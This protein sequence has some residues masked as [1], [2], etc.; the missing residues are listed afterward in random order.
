MSYNEWLDIDV[1]EDYLDG[2]LDASTMHKIERISLE[3]P[4]V[5]E[6]LEGLSQSPKRTQTLSLLQKQL[7]ARITQKPIEAKRWRI[8]SQRL[9]IAAA[10]AVLFVTV[11]ILFWMKGSHTQMM[12]KKTKQ[13]GV[14]SNSQIT[15]ASPQFKPNTTAAIAAVK[16]AAIKNKPIAPPTNKIPDIRIP[17]N[18]V[19]PVTQA[20][21]VKPVLAAVLTTTAPQNEEPVAEAPASAKMVK[22]PEAIR[23][24][25][26]AGKAP[27]IYVESNISSM[28]LPYTI[29][30]KVFTKT[31]GSPLPGALVKIAG[32]NKATVTN[33]RGEFTLPADSS[34]Q[35]LS[36]AYLGYTSQEIKA[37]PN[38]EVNVALEASDKAYLNEVMV[39]NPGAV[40][41]EQLPEFTK[42]SAYYPVGGWINYF[43]YLKSNNE[44]SRNGTSGKMVTLKFDVKANG[45]PVHIQVIKSEGKKYDA[46][47]V[48]LLKDGPKWQA[49]HQ[50]NNGTALLNIQ[51]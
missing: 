31:D 10:A 22:K 5:A 47:A 29:N 41:A 19:V 51:F 24:R 43:S 15:A 4:F 3:D 30:G 18:S 39:T 20:D 6:A 17:N 14:I 13:P 50:G 8:T 33:N 37:K 44:L 16:P 9:S 21:T 23:E 1:L 32:T 26:L 45:S 38:Q 46:A 7:E 11:S 28:N 40:V 49:V 36:I 2:K 35:H 42:T 34:A 12:A 48:R 27:G 25:P